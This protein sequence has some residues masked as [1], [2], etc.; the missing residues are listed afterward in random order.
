MN[1]SNQ[2]RH[3]ALALIALLI[4]GTGASQSLEAH[5]KEQKPAAERRTL[6]GGFAMVAYPSNWGESGRMT[7]IINQRD[8]LYERNLGS[9]TGEIAAAMSEYNPDKNWALAS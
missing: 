6:I 9:K 3:S 1:S 8:K 7:F 2:H 4:M 5:A